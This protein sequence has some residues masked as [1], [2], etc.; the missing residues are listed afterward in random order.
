MSWLAGKRTWGILHAITWLSVCFFAIVA[1][2]QQEPASAPVT[3]SLSD[4]IR[5]AQQNE[6]QFASALAVQKSA[7]VGRYLAKAALL[8]SVTYHNEVLYTQPNGQTNQ[9]GQV[10]TQP[11]PV[12]IANNAIHE[13]TSQASIN[14]TVGLKQFAESRVA[15]ANAARAAA[16]L[17]ISRR[18][19]VSTVV[20]LYYSVAATDTKH[21]LLTEALREAQSFTDLTRKR[22]DAREV[23]HADVVK[24]Q[25]QLQQRQRDVADAQLAKDKAHIELGVLLFPDPRTPYR[26]EDPA[27]PPD[28]PTHDEVNRLA[29]SNNPELQ[30]A[31]AD[32]R[33]SDAEVISARAAYLPDLGLNFSYGI[34]APQFAK[35]GPDDVRNLGYSIGARLD[36]PV[37][38]WFSTQKRVKQNEFRR[39]AARVNLSAAKRRLIATLE[40]TYAEA[41]SERNQLGLLEQSVRTAEESLRLTKLRYA[42]GEA[43]ALEV[44]DAQSSFVAAGQA[45]ADGVLRYQIALAA[46]QTM[47]GTL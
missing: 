26:T 31:L 14:E 8:P 42:A 28:L 29:A 41:A 38:D 21:Q 6:P 47:V 13:Y 27:P 18:G 37:W 11:S 4:A 5:R 1:G 20:D 25:L 43:S 40:E 16:E 9:G 39:D 35:N 34:D 44:V 33:A 12:F 19:L 24:A 7:S 15:S 45:Q 36:I 32:I 30:S 23:A 17:E 10:G 2:A 3:I 46:L 22:E